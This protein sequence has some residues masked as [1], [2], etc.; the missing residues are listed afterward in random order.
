MSVTRHLPLVLALCAC[1][2]V[3]ETEGINQAVD[4]PFAA[5][6]DDC[7]PADGPA[8]ALYLTHDE[9]TEAQA[10]SHPHVAVSVY[11][12]VSTL[13]GRTLEWEGGSSGMGWA[14]RCESPGSCT[15]AESALVR[16]DELTPDGLLLGRL[17]LRFPE[18]DSVS[19]AFTASRLAFQ[20]LCG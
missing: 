2:P 10:P 3:D 4:F 1:S 5:F 8:T 17:R 13:L 16:F 11:Q 14:G 7:G 9:V 20:P 18:G 19:G 12:G 15:G 6:H